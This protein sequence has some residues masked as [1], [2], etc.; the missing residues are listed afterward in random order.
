MKKRLCWPNRLLFIVSLFFCSS[1]AFAQEIPLEEK[2]LIEKS[3]S[4]SAQPKD[5]P[6][7]REKLHLGGNIWL[8]FFGSFYV[9]VSPMIG[10]EVTKLKTVAGVGGT[11]I[12]QGG[13]GQPTDVAAGPRIFV[14][15]PIWRSIFAHAEYEWMNATSNQFYSFDPI[16]APNIPTF[17][18]KWEGSPLV[19][20]GFYQGQG[21]Q[22]GSFISVMYNLGYPL[23]GFVSP[24]GLG[25]RNSPLILRFGFFF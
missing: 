5:I 2:P 23:K 10:Y 1:I 8:G 3:I 16:S 9:D 18:K 13:F 15:Q 20:L 17:P 14:R 21:G 22:A 6:A 25:G 24:Q 12:Y 19:G 4:Q 7:W 11:L